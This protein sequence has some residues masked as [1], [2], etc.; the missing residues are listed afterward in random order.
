MPQLKIQTSKQLIKK[1]FKEPEVRNVHEVINDEPIKVINQAI[2]SASITTNWSNQHYESSDR[3][4]MDKRSTSPYF[5]QSNRHATSM[6][7]SFREVQ[8][9][10][11]MKVQPQQ[12][13]QQNNNQYY[14]ALK[15]LVS[16]LGANTTQ[17]QVNDVLRQLNSYESVC[18]SL[19]IQDPSMQNAAAHIFS[20]GLREQQYSE[21]VVHFQDPISDR[22]NGALQKKLVT[23][24]NKRNDTSYNF[25]NGVEKQPKPQKFAKKMMSNNS[26]PKRTVVKVMLQP[27][28]FRKENQPPK[29]ESIERYQAKSLHSNSIAD[30]VFKENMNY[31]NLQYNQ[32]C[33][34]SRRSP[35]RQFIEA[36]GISC[37]PGSYQKIIKDMKPKQSTIGTYK[38]VFEG[39]NSLPLGSDDPSVPQNYA[40]NIMKKSASNVKIGTSI[41]NYFSCQEPQII[42]NSS[43]PQMNQNPFTSHR[44]SVQVFDQ[45]QPLQY[46]KQCYRDVSPNVITFG[47]PSIPQNSEYQIIKGHRPKSTS[48]Q[49]RHN[50][51]YKS[52]VSFY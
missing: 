16:K 41:Q 24:I 42:N 5:Q 20:K 37:L 1:D 47:S 3:S 19:Y 9:P 2:S 13:K 4:F 27:D 29:T 46:N 28:K 31:Q 21:N 35:Q 17:E 22:F 11:K 33:Q 30:I 50:I 36:S 32:Q 38:R 14:A 49:Q 51:F 8:Q 12:Q 43:K 23:T 10:Q 26:S 40:C 6:S 48:Q 52:N 18:Q 45:T 25:I 7:H 15:K 44:M 34:T 39:K